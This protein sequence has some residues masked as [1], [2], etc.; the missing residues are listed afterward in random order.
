MRPARRA[1]ALAVLV[2]FAWRLLDRAHRRRCPTASR[3]TP[4]P[5]SRASPI[6]SPPPAPIRRRPVG[7]RALADVAGGRARSCRSSSAWTAC[8]RNT[9][10]WR[11]RSR[12]RPSG[13][14]ASRARCASWRRPCAPW[15]PGSVATRGASYSWSAQRGWLSGIGTAPDG[16]A[17]A[18]R[19][20]PI[21]TARAASSSATASRSPSRT[22]SSATTP[23]WSEALA[24]VPRRVTCRRAQ[25]TVSFSGTVAP[26]AALRRA[27][28]RRRC[29]SP[30]DE[31]RRTSPAAG[32]CSSAAPLGA[33]GVPPAYLPPI[34]PRGP[35]LPATVSAAVAPGV[36]DLHAAADH[37]HGARRRPSC[38][39]AAASS[40]TS[41]C[42]APTDPRMDV[43]RRHGIHHRA[44]L[45]HPRAGRAVAYTATWNS[46]APG[47]YSVDGVLTSTSHQAGRRRRVRR[48]IG[49]GDGRREG[50]EAGG[51]RRER[52]A[53]ARA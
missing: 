31:R 39:S 26:S 27:Q 49:R 29:A 17:S 19:P 38:A 22:R 43:E 44:H 2:A 35:V 48:A 5:S 1:T 45:P 23:C 15:W 6:R 20:S 25:F 10:R 11:G 9:P 13:A 8:R 21:S 40:S 12:S 52:L 51:S 16:G 53:L 28:A 7:Y 46:R 18:L 24:V 37:Q 34:S 4:P 3:A 50:R 42:V 47:S 33:A 30:C 41:A 32:S 14:C 36:R